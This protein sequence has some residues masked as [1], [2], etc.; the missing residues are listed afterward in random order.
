LDA[1]SPSELPGLK[2]FLAE[3]GTPLRRLER[4]GRL[5]A[6]GR[7]H[8]LCFHP[9]AGHPASGWTSRPLALAGLAALRLVLE[10][11]VGEELL[12]PRRPDELSGA[13]HAIEDPV[14]ELHRA[15]PRR[16]RSTPIRAGASY[17]S[18]SA[19]V[20]VWLSACRRVSS[21]R[22]AS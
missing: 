12:L 21:R 5:L 9:F 16:G 13:V 11:L 2:A 15:L 4:H 6:A 1:A 8:R 19:R 3:H 20:L 10:V 14:L 7:A 22:N 18:A 17:D